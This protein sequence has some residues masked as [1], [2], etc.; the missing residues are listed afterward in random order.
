MDYYLGNEFKEKLYFK[1]KIAVFKE[2]LNLKKFLK[3]N[4]FFKKNYKKNFFFKK[5]S[6]NKKNF[7]NMIKNN[8]IVFIIKDFLKYHFFD[9]KKKF[10][11]KKKKRFR[12][13]KKLKLKFR[14]KVLYLCKDNKWWSSIYIL[15]LLNLKFFFLSNYYSHKIYLIGIFNFFSQMI[16]IKKK[17]FKRYRRK[18]KFKRDF[19]R[20]FF[21]KKAKLN[22]VLNILE[23]EKKKK[24]KKKV[25]LK[26]NLYKSKYNIYPNLLK[27]EEIKI[28]FL[29]YSTNKSVENLI[30]SLNSLMF[31]NKIEKV[32]ELNKTTF[33]SVNIPVK[34]YFILKENL[35]FKIKEE[36]LKF[37]FI[38]IKFKN[39]SFSINFFEEN[40]LKNSNKQEF[41]EDLMYFNYLNFFK[42]KIFLIKLFFIIIFNFISL[43]NNFKKLILKKI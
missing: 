12:M 23:D 24:G 15:F 6:R 41:F 28:Y 22:I 16:N 34:N 29:I 42:N 26:K 20:N 4:F 36:N 14:S 43:I 37:E 32:K 11:L 25:M 18:R 13:F 30:Y 21:G 7:F 19:F 8:S 1:K 38:S 2:K 40:F 9:I 33:F 10:R 27:V 5:F 17:F 3:K 35:G 39:N 31:N